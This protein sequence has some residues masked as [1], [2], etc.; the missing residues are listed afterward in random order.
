M[1]IQRLLAGLG[2]FVLLSSAGAANVL[3]QPTL[4]QKHTGAAA[5]PAA[6]RIESGRVEPGRIEP[7]RIELGRPHAGPAA[8]PEA[9]RGVIRELANR[10]YLTSASAEPGAVLL[11]AAI[12]AF[13]QDHGLALTA[14][15]SDA[16]LQ[17]LI[18][19]S[20]EAQG[21]GAEAGETARRL[22]SEI[23]R[24]LGALG[25]A[26]G[27]GDPSAAI[28]RFERE[29]ELPLTGR[30]SAPLVRTLLRAAAAKGI[31]TRLLQ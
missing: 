26:A 24:V 15:P 7:R 5:S 22:Q 31:A 18:L 13:E 8:S 29:H 12:L 6:A 14:E 1:T 2:L 4:R 28:H 30:I 3:M 27:K 20:G 11:Q 25:Y 10:G 17:A 23:A 16:V 9:R 21:E 19:G